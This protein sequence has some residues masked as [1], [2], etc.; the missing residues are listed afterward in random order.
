[1]GTRYPRKSA[2]RLG[3][4]PSWQSGHLETLAMIARGAAQS[5]PGPYE[6]PSAA[7]AAP[8]VHT[9]KG[10]ERSQVSRRRLTHYLATA[11]VSQKQAGERY[12][13]RLY[14]YLGWF[15]R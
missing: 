6:V 9:R 8:Q 14:R 4:R 1:M 2:G 7:E 10:V 5:V 11:A 12:V 13:G 3:Q 15:P